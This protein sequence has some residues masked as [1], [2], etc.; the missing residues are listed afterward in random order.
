MLKDKELATAALRLGE[1]FIIGMNRMLKQVKVSCSDEEYEAFRRAVGLSIGPVDM[2]LM[3]PLYRAHP[4]LM[5]EGY[6]LGPN[7]S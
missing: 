2:R 7:E 1:A 5:P 6:E 3:D 4:E